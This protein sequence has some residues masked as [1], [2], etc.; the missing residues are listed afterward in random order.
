M[1]SYIIIF[2]P[3]DQN[4]EVKAQAE[5]SFYLKNF[6]SENETIIITDAGNIKAQKYPLT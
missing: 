5:A 4:Y 1:R 3:P 2:N 6:K